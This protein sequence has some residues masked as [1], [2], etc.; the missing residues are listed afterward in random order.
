MGAD[1]QNPL[2]GRRGRH[3]RRVG[4]H[5]GHHRAQAGRRRL[6]REQANLR[7]VFDVVNVGMLVIAEDGEVKQVNDTI[8]RWV[9]K[10]VAAW[11]GGNRATSSVASTRWPTRPAAGTARS[12]ARAPSA[13]RSQRCCK[14]GSPSMTSRRRPSSRSMEAGPPVARGRRRSARLGREAARDSGHEQH[15]RPQAGRR[16]LAADRRGTG[17]LEQGPGAVRL[18]GLA[19]PA[20]AAADGERLRA[21][22]AEE[23][24]GPTGR[25]GR[26]LHR[27]RRGRHQADGD[28][29]QGPAGLP[30]V[31][32]RRQEPVPT[33]AG[34]ALRQ[35][36]DNLH[37]SIQETGAEITHGAL[38]T[39]RADPS[40]L[41]QLFQNL[42]GNAIKFRGEAPPKIHVD[43]RRDG[44]GWRFSVSRQRHRHRARS[45]RIK[46]S[47]SSAA[48]TA[49]NSMRARASA[50]RSARR[51]WTATAG[52]SGWNRNRDR[53]PPSTSRSPRDGAARLATPKVS[54]VG[55]SAR[56]RASGLPGLGRNAARRPPETP[57]NSLT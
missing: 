6:A 14:P 12:A 28:A 23:V 51:S 4:A 48:C 3:Y 18:R 42:I 39:V 43:A 32:T 52:G 47:R 7:A 53:A 8:S 35:A 24:R 30:R 33:D 15:H 45:S 2:P 34:E 44:D 57:L 40:Q 13:T 50:W 41:A 22:A 1:R 36:L 56:G 46:S 31:G 20:G 9:K 17:P 21:T 38:P 29:D 16:G 27:L 25:G 49:A 10:D 37:A 5:G 19:R 55:R 54:I 26:R 11:E